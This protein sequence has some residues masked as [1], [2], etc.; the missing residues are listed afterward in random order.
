MP[1]T[2]KI[3]ADRGALRLPVMALMVATVALAG[4]MGGPE[5]ASKSANRP[6]SPA[7]AEGLRSPLISELQSRRSILP[8]GG[9]YARVADAVLASDSGAAAAELRIAQL[10]AEA[11]EKN[12]LPRIG[13][14]VSLSAL[15]GLAAGFLVEQALFDNGRRRAERAYAAADVEV[16]AVSLAVGINQRVYDG[17]R[18]YVLAEEARAQAAVAERAVAHLD[19]FANQ[20]HQRVEG[21]LSDRSEEQVLAQRQVEMRATLAADREAAA[22]SEAELAA[23]L[24]APLSGVSGIDTL[25][26]SQTTVEPLSVVKARGEATRSL[27]EAEAAKA[28]LL[29]GVT[30]SSSVMGSGINPGIELTG[31]LFNPGAKAER[32]ALDATQDVVTRQTAEVRDSATRRIV[33]LESQI[34]Q[35]RTRQAQGVEVLNQTEQNLALVGEQYKVGRRTLL[36]LAGQYDSFARLQRDQASLRYEIAL[37]ELEVARD[38]GVLVDGARM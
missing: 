37:L 34:A 1:S 9:A 2:R 5:A 20:M 27:A 35:L 19:E 13:P 7:G 29:P 31:G 16:A 24:S 11:R 21:G 38:R 33:T 6:D 23:M 4:C 36:E 22:G 18:H 10:R 14:Q 8:A 12:W 17:L 28:S 26:V 30:A 25:A 3:M 15:S 32:Q